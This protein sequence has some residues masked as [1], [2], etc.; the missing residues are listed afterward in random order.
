[1]HAA[2]PFQIRVL[3]SVL[4]VVAASRRLGDSLDPIKRIAR[5]VGYGS[6]VSLHH[7]FEWLLRSTPQE[8]RQGGGLWLAAER[9]RAAVETMRAA[10]GAT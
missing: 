9:L 3:L 10:G 8:I 6:V 4:R 5:D 2:G 1:M 7:A